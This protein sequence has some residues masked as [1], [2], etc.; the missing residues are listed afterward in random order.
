MVGFGDFTIGI[1][2]TGLFMFVFIAF[3]GQMAL[4]N[5]T[6][7]SI[8]DNGAVSEAYGSINDTLLAVKP[9]TDENNEGFFDSPISKENTGG[10]GGIVIDSIVGITQ[11]I[12]SGFVSGTFGVVANFFT[13]VLGLDSTLVFNLMMSFFTITIILLAWRVYRAGN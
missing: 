11:L 8:L 4:D 2:L 5:P 7:Q 1:L 10:A 9:S 6:N 3:G 12:S 13:V